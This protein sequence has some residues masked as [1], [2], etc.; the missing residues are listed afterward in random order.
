MKQTNRDVLNEVLRWVLHPLKFKQNLS[1]ESG[2]YNVLHADGNFRRCKPDL[3]AWLADC[4]EYSDLHHLEQHG[5]FWFKCTKNEHGDYV[6]PDKQHPWW[7][8]N[9][10]RTLSDANT[11]AAE[12]E[13]LPRH[14]H[15]GFNVVRHIPCMVSD[16]PKPDL[17][18]T[19]PIGML[20]HLQKWIFHF[21]KTHE[22]LDKYNV[23][24]L[25]VPA[26]Y[27][28]TPTTKSYEEVSQ[29]NGKEMKKMSQYLIGVVTQSRQRGS[30]TQR[31]I[32]N[33]A[34]ESTRA[35]LEFYMYARYQS[36][37][38]AIL[39]YMEGAMCRFDTFNDVFLLGRAG[40]KAPAKASA[41]RTELVKKRKVDNE[42]NAE[43]R[44]PSRKRGKMNA[45]RDFI[46]HEID[47]SKELN[48]DFKFP[49][50]HSMSHW[51][52]QIR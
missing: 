29:W 8:H 6:P 7:D 27:D 5:C 28:L 39:S 33:R 12:A 9:L 49:K 46:S 51:V 19:M 26:Y 10:Y 40:K 52:E 41:L 36:H 32:F 17:L 31:P 3:A 4:P 24:C 23:I 35:L 38:D 43:T 20:D 2:Y 47:V 11:K 22:Q 14:V 15:P 21:I 18:H 30:P 34:I 25:S 45:W 1:A 16:L 42:T 44:T 48:A 37:D 13:I 50:I